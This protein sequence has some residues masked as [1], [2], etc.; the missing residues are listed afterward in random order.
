[1]PRLPDLVCTIGV[2]Q[3]DQVPVLIFHVLETD[4]AE[5]TGVV[6]E[7]I[8]SAKVLDGRVDNG[9]T[10]LHAVVVGGCLAASGFDFVDNDIS[11]LD[12][13]STLALESVIH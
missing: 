5:D 1:M 7:N 12:I 9:I 2:Y 11:S 4:I 10:L 3:V 6:D 13:G 8:H